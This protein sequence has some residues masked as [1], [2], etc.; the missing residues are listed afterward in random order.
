[1][2][3]P[4]RIAAATPIARRFR[5]MLATMSLLR[6]ARAAVHLALWSGACADRQERVGS[7]RGSEGEA[8]VVHRKGLDTPNA[9]TGCH[10]D[11]DRAVPV[12]GGEL[13]NHPPPARGAPEGSVAW[14]RP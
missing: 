7:L 2:M 8:G 3:R 10:S 1:M 11:R 5:S 14:L 6:R 9:G 4:A 13:A 12:R